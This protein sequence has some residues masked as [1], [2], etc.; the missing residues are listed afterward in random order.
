MAENERHARNEA[1]LGE[2]LQ[3]AQ[4]AIRMLARKGLPVKVGQTDQGLL[5]QIEGARYCQHCRNWRLPEEMNT[6]HP[7]ACLACEP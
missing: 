6:T 5:I 7:T 3:I 4:E 1:T 2:Q